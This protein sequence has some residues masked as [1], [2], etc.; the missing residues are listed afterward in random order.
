MIYS[1]TKFAQPPKQSNF[2]FPVSYS[3]NVILGCPRSGTTFL[4][5]SLKAMP[6]SECISGH[7]LPIT[8]PHLVNQN[9]STE[10]Y[11]ALAVGFEFA[12]KDFMECID[13]ERFIAIQK[14]LNRYTSL[15]ELIKALQRKRKIERVIYK[16]PFLGF[17]PEFT[18]N[19][20]P[21]CR[22]VVI[23]RDG[24][25]VADSL[26]RRY[27]VLTDEKLM[28]LGTAEMPLGRKYDRRY[29]PWWIEEGQEEKFL[30]STPYIRS[31]WMW[32]EIARRCQDFC[33]R[34]DI[35]NSNRVLLVKY[36]DL[37]SNPLTKAK[38]IVEHFGGSM[39]PR[40]EK[41][42]QEATTNSIGIHQR[43][44]NYEIELATEIAEIELKQYG[45]L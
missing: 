1:T 37:V 27:Q 13:K 3:Y 41:K 30:N 36:E 4:I 7:L 21:N 20:L 16:E 18:Y 42:F 25:D 8:I 9:L 40:L 39:N 11:Q 6:N 43:R 35:I 19:A 28:Y 33:S 32:K 2:T 23:Y 31:V 45:Y 5:N 22:I 12:I 14:W 44:D 24:R 10:I 34:P 26:S 38:L 17:A 15:S 29:V